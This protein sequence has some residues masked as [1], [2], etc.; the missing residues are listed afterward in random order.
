MC[1][2]AAPESEHCLGV[3]LIFFLCTEIGT[4]VR[5]DMHQ[6]VCH[7]Q[8]QQQRLLSLW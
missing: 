6:P 7:L 3:I 2:V 1:A 5:C 4:T 8:Q